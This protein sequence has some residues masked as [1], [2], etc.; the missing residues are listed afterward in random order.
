[1]AE[2]KKYL[3]NKPITAA[4]TGIILLKLGE[5]EL[6]KGLK[7]ILKILLSDAEVDVANVQTVEGDRVGVTAGGA[8]LADLAILLSFGKLH[9]YWDT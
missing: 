2:L 4:S 9:N 5:F 6:A 3:L 1:M 7:H 8:G